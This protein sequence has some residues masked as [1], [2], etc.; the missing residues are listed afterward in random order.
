M[1][2]IGAMKVQGSYSQGSAPVYL[3][4]LLCSGD[5]VS[6]LDCGRRFQQPTGLLTCG[7]NQ[8][9]AIRCTGKN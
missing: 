6:L 2:A 9:V 8:D 4:E 5:E 3:S 7:S 1:Y